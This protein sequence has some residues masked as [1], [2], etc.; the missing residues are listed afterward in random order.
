MV[1]I[2]QCSGVLI[3]KFIR[4]KKRLKFPSDTTQISL[5]NAPRMVFRTLSCA[6]RQ[7]RRASCDVQLW[8][9]GAATACQTCLWSP[10]R[11]QPLAPRSFYH[12]SGG[13]HCGTTLTFRLPLHCKSTSS[14][15][16]TSHRSGIKL[17]PRPVK[18][19]R[20]MYSGEHDLI[21][22]LSVLLQEFL[23]CFYV[24]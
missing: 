15:L 9:A 4:T 21:D 5:L 23:E 18:M 10:G 12:L 22:V 13:K 16:S 6:V 19:M 2:G 14:V 7:G 1:C 3:F 11:R 24:T 17:S 20:I 8:G